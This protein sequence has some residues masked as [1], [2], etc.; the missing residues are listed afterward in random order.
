MSDNIFNFVKRLTVFSIITVIASFIIIRY[1][2]SKFVTPM[3]PY[4]MLFFFFISILSYYIMIK[5]SEQRFAR[6][7]S[8]FMLATFLKLMLYL[9][10]LLIYIFLIN[11]GD[12]VGFIGAFFIYYL[13][14]T[15]FETVYLLIATK[16]N[17]FE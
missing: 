4:I 11:R 2:P 7:V 14:F 13:M 17:T 5:S 16:K 12:A 1:I 6:F 8:T 15:I 9:G 3:L 10:I